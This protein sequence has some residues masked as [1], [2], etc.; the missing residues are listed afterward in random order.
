[1]QEV[2]EAQNQF[3]P[4][5]YQEGMMNDSCLRLATKKRCLE[6]PA[7]AL[8]LTLLM[9]SQTYAAQG[10]RTSGRTYTKEEVERLINDVEQSG[11]EFR[12]DFDSWLDRSRIDGRNREDRY[13]DQIKRLTDALSALRSN[14][15]RN[16]DWW[17]ARRDMVRVLNE[18]R[19]VNTMMSSRE[20]G[21]N[22]DRQWGRLRRNLNRLA[23]AFNLPPVGSAFSGNQP[24]FPGQ[25]GRVP[26][27]AVGTFRGWT[28]TGEAEL[29]ISANG[30]ATA[31]SLST[32][33]IYNGRFAND[34]LYFDWGSF[35][36]VREGRGFATVEIGNQ[37]NRTSYT[38][39]GSPGGQGPFYPGQN[40]NVPN[41]AVGT[42]RGWTNNTESE[43]T[44]MD[45]GT[46]TVRAASS[47]TIYQGRFEN[48]VLTFDWGSF[49][50]VREGNGITTVEI[51][52]PQNRTSYRRVN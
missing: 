43:L 22:L 50:L 16:E 25:G 13:N 39:V 40:G 42:F 52:N 33:A 15:D 10:Q 26:N 34:V 4:A 31:R 38:R 8:G 41:W 47:G 1:M 3:K 24:N 44:I 48:N 51:N 20:V 23:D 37:R 36:I 7:L 9:L 21:G 18:A 6:L 2:F 45:N 12:R 30:A 19:P 49:R 27:W 46:A 11:N 17:L 29:T 14:F 5:D 28:N 32:N 35:N